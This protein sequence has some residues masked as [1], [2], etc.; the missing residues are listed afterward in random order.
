MPK[1]LM[2]TW[3]W[4]HPT[5]SEGWGEWRNSKEIQHSGHAPRSGPEV[6]NGRSSAKAGVPERLRCGTIQEMV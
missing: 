4:C 2:N 6:K 1:L 5:S 3:W